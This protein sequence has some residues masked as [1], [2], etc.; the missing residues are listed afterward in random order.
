MQVDASPEAEP[1][2]AFAR[3]AVPI[4]AAAADVPA[5]DAPELD[6][7]DRDG[8][9]KGAALA[10]SWDRREVRD[11]PRAHRHHHEAFAVRPAQQDWAE[12]VIR[13]YE[14][15]CAGGLGA[16]AWRTAW[17]TPQQSG[18]PAR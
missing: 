16:C 1:V 15:G 17:W 2:V 14:Q 8:V 6:L 4:A 12:R 18:G 10:R 5:I 13:A 3:S 11:R 7:A 9:R